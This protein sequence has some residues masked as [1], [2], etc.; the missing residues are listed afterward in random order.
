[1]ER[2]LSK[3]RV[4][5]GLCG[6]LLMASL[7]RQ[8]PMVYAMFL[9]L[10]VLS[11]LGFFLPWVS[12][13]A[14]VIR[15]GQEADEPGEVVEGQL[16]SLRMAVERRAWWP[17]FMV[18]IET[19][20]QWAGKDLV[21]RQT[22]PVIRGGTTLDLGRLVRFPVRG[23]Y[24]LIEVSLS[25]GFPLGLIRAR[26]KMAP[27]NISQLVLPRAQAVHWP[28]HWQVS[29][30][31]LGEQT[32]RRLGQSFELG[33]LRKYQMGEFLGRVSWRASARIGEL[34]VQH[35]QQSGSVLL[36]LVTEI[37]A[38]DQV[39]DPHSAAERV[40]RLAAGVSQLALAQGVRLRAYLPPGPQ[41]L[42]DMAQVSRALAAALPGSLGLD[43]AIAWAARDM[44]AGEQLAVVVSGRHKADDLLSCLSAP[45]FQGC[46]VVVYIASGSHASPAELGAA[47]ELQ[48]ALHVA[49]IAAYTEL[50]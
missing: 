45:K 35:F 9:F 27:Q 44:S 36:R 46:L 8:D 37:P 4:L 42:H 16:A 14:M 32:T 25:S 23:H 47:T 41:A 29:D 5:L 2:W 50:P 7:N 19:R 43:Q 28:Q 13:R 39:G 26:H 11:L 40:I 30:D 12:L 17:A 21:L 48:Q 6:V 20:W 3:S 33:M 10:A 49:G 15:A 38:V 1:M 31:P 24:R 18:D 34:V 22:L